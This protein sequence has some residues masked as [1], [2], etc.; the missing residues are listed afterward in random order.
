MTKKQLTR[1]MQAPHRSRHTTAAQ[2]KQT[3]VAVCRG[4]RS[5]LPMWYSC[6]CSKL[7]NGCSTCSGCSC[8]PKAS[9]QDAPH[10]L[11]VLG[12]LKSTT[13][14][15]IVKEAQAGHAAR[16]NDCVAEIPAQQRTQLTCA[17]Q[18]WTASCAIKGV[19]FAHAGGL[20]GGHKQTEQAV[21]MQQ[22]PR[23]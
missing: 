19:N 8:W 9:R 6:C 3:T 14:E 21:C 7:Y 5:M 10:L 4:G 18:A 11:L 2:Q 16:V 23:H 15:G 22:L 1:G 12:P 13:Q 17:Q 20:H